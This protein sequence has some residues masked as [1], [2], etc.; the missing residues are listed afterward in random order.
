MFDHAK[1]ITYSG[2]MSMCNVSYSGVIARFAGKGCVA[3]GFILGIYDLTE[4][5]PGLLKTGLALLVIGI[6]ASAYGLVQRLRPTRPAQ[7]RTR[8]P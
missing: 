6:V 8:V 7:D 1:T 5:R 3:L 2:S 4:S